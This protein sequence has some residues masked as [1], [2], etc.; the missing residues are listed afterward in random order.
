MQCSLSCI[1]LSLKRVRTGSVVSGSV[2]DRHQNDA[3]PDPDPTFHFR[4]RSRS[5][6]CPMLE[7]IFCTFIQS[8]AS[9][10]CFTYLVIVIFVIIFNILESILKFSDRKYSLVLHLVEMGLDRRTS[11]HNSRNEKIFMRANSDTILFQF[12]SSDTLGSD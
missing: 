5:G 2:V 7:N 8:S 6:S 11:C 10:H 12:R 1:T 9:L 3:D 4:S